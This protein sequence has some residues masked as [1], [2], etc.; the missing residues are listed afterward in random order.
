MIFSNGI[1]KG[2][3]YLLITYIIIEDNGSI[4]VESDSAIINDNTSTTGGV[5]HG[6]SGWNSSGVAYNLTCYGGN[7]DAA[8]GLSDTDVITAF[9]FR[10]AKGTTAYTG[11][12]KAR[13]K[14][15]VDGTV[16]DIACP[17]GYTFQTIAD[18]GSAVEALRIHSNGD[19]EL[20]TIGQSLI[21][22]SPNGTGYKITVDDS[23]NLTT[24]IV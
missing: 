20:P 18:N 10:G 8:T 17:I 7:P 16:T 14:A 24:T 22:S 12:S 4:T 6:S 5:T 13:I 19:V 23:G 2:I 9:T 11:L 1:G 15:I 3:A 21:M